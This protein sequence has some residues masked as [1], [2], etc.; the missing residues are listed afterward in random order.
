M[1]HGL[2]AQREMAITMWGQ[3][4]R[5]LKGVVLLMYQF[6]TAMASLALE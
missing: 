4:M 6:D 2:I 1:H 3:G 5:H